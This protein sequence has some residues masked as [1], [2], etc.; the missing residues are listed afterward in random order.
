MVL[1]K[2]S[3]MQNA[4]KD[5]LLVYK[6][7]DGWEPLCKFLEKDIPDKPYPW[8]NK[9]GSDIERTID[10]HPFSK[11]VQKEAMISL[12]CIVGVVGLVLYCLMIA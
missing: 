10:N 2:S 12:A 11:R 9:D 1:S 8:R 4:P 7:G 3:L 6:L 5:K